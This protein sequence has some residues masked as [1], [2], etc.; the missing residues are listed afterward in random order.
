M[1]Y[2]LESMAGDEQEVISRVLLC[3]DKGLQYKLLL[4]AII[5]DKAKLTCHLSDSC[6]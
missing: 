5:H 2:T 4:I 3:I 6:V 1:A